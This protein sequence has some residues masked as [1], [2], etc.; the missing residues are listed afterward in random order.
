MGTPNREAHPRNN[1]LPRV[2]VWSL[3]AVILSINSNNYSKK[4]IRT[5]FDLRNSSDLLRLVTRGRIRTLA[6]GEVSVRLFVQLTAR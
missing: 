1:K 3:S 5:T 2:T 4:Q 6:S